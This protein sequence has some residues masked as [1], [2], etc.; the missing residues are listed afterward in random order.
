MWGGE[1][2]GTIMNN[3]V[4]TK[5]RLKGTACMIY[6]DF[7]HESWAVCINSRLYRPIH[8]SYTAIMPE[9]IHTIMYRE[10]Y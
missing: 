1:L 3:E 5:T 8:I 2:A 10:L 9:N 7:I 6:S 4:T